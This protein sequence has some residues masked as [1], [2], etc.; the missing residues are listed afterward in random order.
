[1]IQLYKTA[2]QTL[3]QY[4]NAHVLKCKSEDFIYL[5]S[6]EPISPVNRW[7]KP[8]FTCTL[9]IENLTIFKLLFFSW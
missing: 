2:E 8:S 9:Y 5:F 6:F 3:N 7:P 4:E 1:M